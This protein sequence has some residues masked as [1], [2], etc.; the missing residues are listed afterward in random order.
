[1]NIKLL[2]TPQ[3]AYNGSW[4]DISLNK[5]Y[6]LIIYLVHKASWVSRDELLGLFYPDLLEENARINLR[7][8]LKRVRK[9]PL[10]AKLESKDAR[11]RLL[12]ASDTRSFQ[13]AIAE[14]NWQVAIKF[15]RGD[16]LEGF[17]E[18]S[19]SLEAWI[20]LER[21]SLQ[22]AYYMAALNCASALEK[23]QKFTEAL[24]LLDNILKENNL[25]EE[26]VQDYMRCAYLDGK[27]QKALEV[28][29]CFKTDLENELAISPLV[30]TLILAEKI[31]QSDGLVLDKGRE[32]GFKTSII[33]FIEELEPSSKPFHNF[34]ARQDAL[35]WL[36]SYWLKAI[37]N[38]GQ[39]VLI[40]G[41]AG[42]GKT[43]L[44]DAFCKSV[45]QDVLIAKG[46]CS[47]YMGVGDPYLVFQDVFA[48]ILRPLESNTKLLEQLLKGR[49]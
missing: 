7:A 13:K 22:E 27:R 46:Q 1:M 37:Y 30:E 6:L 4:Q 38:H 20:E 35:D 28:F 17:Y 12:I 15:Y 14:K 25:N 3:I 33:S 5:T 2:G 23:E 8:L 42:T 41:E 49:I 18:K 36:R 39:I 31:K 44:I 9:I 48:N 10:P 16:F 11:L 45:Q 29:E 21:R 40:H 47:T 34:V 26:L 19:L 24:T 32:K 43:T